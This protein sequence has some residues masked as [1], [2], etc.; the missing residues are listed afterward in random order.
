MTSNNL[1]REQFH[2]IQM[3]VLPKLQFLNRLCARVV[4]LD[5]PRDDPLWIAAH[6]ARDAMQDLFNACDPSHAA[7]PA[8]MRR[9]WGYERNR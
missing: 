3:S 9:H 6:R 7:P 5:F 2:R 8:A 4:A 1:D